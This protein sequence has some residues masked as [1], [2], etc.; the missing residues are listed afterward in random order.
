MNENEAALRDK[1]VYFCVP[2]PDITNY[3]DQSVLRDAQKL[4]MEYEEQYL[5]RAISP[6]AVV[7]GILDYENSAE[8]EIAFWFS[9]KMLTL[10]DY[11][12]VFGERLTDRMRVEI[13]YAWLH[14][15]PII[16]RPES[17]PA[18]HEYLESMKRR[19]GDA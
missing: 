8:L 19:N 11:L 7:P 16:S 4:L 15:I 12:V 2:N 9:Q 5:C 13:D 3:M 17:F 14:S 10:C 18:V 6:H 1:M